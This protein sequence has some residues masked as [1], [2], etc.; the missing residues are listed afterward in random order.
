M[1]HNPLLFYLRCLSDDDE[2]D[3][4]IRRE[5]VARDFFLLCDSENA[6]RS[7]WVQSEREVITSLAEKVHQVVDLN[8]DWKSQLKAIK[9]LSIRSTIFVSYSARDRDVVQ[10]LVEGLRS[11]DYRVLT[12][13]ELRP[14]DSWQSRLEEMINE[15]LQ[16][17][18]VLVV[19][20][21]AALQSEFVLNETMYALA[22]FQREGRS[23]VIPLVIGD[24]GAVAATIQTQTRW[25]E[26][27][28]MHWLQIDPVNVSEGVGLLVRVLRDIGRP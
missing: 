1:G 27:A 13:L 4:L 28:Q 25:R 12:D 5:L 19:L 21:P 9:E 6:R 15:A 17:G 23:G 8:S 26:L 10:A 7:R 3:D 11:H 18:F 20:S 14:G 2:V 16:H 24:S 22:R